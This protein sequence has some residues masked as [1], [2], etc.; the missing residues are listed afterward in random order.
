MSGIDGG[1]GSI[2]SFNGNGHGKN[3]NGGSDN[4]FEPEDE[5]EDEEDGHEHEYANIAQTPNLSVYEELVHQVITL[6]FHDRGLTLDFS[7]E[8]AEELGQVLAD[9]MSYLSRKRTYEP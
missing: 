2:F 5:F 4:H 3:G 6:E 7:Y 9:I 1:N 8:E